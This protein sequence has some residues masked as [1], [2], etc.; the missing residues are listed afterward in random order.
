MIEDVLISKFSCHIKRVKKAN[1]KIDLSNIIVL[2]LLLLSRD[3]INLC[4][5]DPL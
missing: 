2:L 4:Y 5:L 1:R 3:M